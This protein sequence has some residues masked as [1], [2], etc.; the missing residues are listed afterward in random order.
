[1][2]GVGQHV[3]DVRYPKLVKPRSGKIALHEVRSWPR[4]FLLD[5]R[6]GPFSAAPSPSSRRLSSGER[7]AFCRRGCPGLAKRRGREAR[8]RCLS[9][10]RGSRGFFRLTSRLFGLAWK[11]HG[12]AMRSS[13]WWRLPG[14]SRWT[15]IGN[16]AWQKSMNRKIL[17]VHLRSP[18]RT[19]PYPRGSYFASISRSCFASRSFLRNS[20][21][22]SRLSV[23]RPSALF[24]S[25][26]SAFFIQFRMVCS[27]D[28]LLGESRGRSS[29]SGKFDDSVSE[30]IGV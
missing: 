3:G 8:H 27:V 22:S 30:F 14:L 10:G 4:T 6:R 20:R 5:R 29:V 28:W 2:P 9:I 26:R 1:M 24:P 13:H 7:P 12:S 16:S 11:A 18:L 19:R 17:V 23:E 15:L 21:S 25:S